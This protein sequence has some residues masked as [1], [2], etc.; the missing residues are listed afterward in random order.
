ML[1]PDGRWHYR[2]SLASRVTLLTTMAV[3]LAVAFVALGA[4]VT[5]RM[6]LQSSLDE[7]LVDRAEDAAA[8]RPGSPSSPTTTTI[9]A[10]LLGASD[11]RIGV[12]QRRRPVAV[13]RHRAT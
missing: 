6:Q 3:G 8:S 4:Y 11:V 1:D 13:P 2:R 9:P 7:S 10:F 12:R 5:V